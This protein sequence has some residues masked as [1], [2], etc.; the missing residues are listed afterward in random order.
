[1]LP[2]HYLKPIILVFHC[3]RLDNWCAVVD[4]VNLRMFLTSLVYK[5]HFYIRFLEVRTSCG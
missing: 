2:T 1:M 5:G 3:L 4:T